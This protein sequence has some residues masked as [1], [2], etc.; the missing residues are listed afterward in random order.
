MPSPTT[1]APTMTVFGRSDAVTACLV[2]TDSLHR[3]WP[4]QVQWVCSQ[5]P[6]NAR[7]PARRTAPQPH[8]NC[9][10]PRRRCKGFLCA[11][12]S[13]R[14]S[15]RLINFSVTFVPHPE[16]RRAS[17]DARCPYGHPPLSL[18]AAFERPLFFCRGDAILTPRLATG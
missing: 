14:T 12:R 16:D 13:G 17:R 2:M 8:D 7:P 1:P 11:V 6:R 4:G 3:D 10:S 9:G 5:P 18:E 15:E